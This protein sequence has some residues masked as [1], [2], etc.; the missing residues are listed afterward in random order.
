M[1][2]NLT[3]FL[4][5]FLISNV[6]YSKDLKLDQC[7]GEN[8]YS[9]QAFDKK[10]TK[11]EE[12]YFLASSLQLYDAKLNEVFYAAGNN[13]EQDERYKLFHSIEENAFYIKA[14]DGL[15]THSLV[16]SDFSYNFS[17]QKYEKNI[18]NLIQ[19]KNIELQIIKLLTIQTIEFL[20]K[21]QTF[22]KIF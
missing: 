19:A 7:F 20:Q 3:F 16:Y 13:I 1:K 2:K 9:L 6:V 10:I 15:I 21:K 14:K 22:L 18:I 11:W 17:K 12:E 8:Y 4:F 5:F